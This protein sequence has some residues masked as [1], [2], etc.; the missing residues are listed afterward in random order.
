MSNTVAQA[1]R[2]VVEAALQGTCY[3]LVDVEFKKER[4]GWNLIIYADK[5]QG[6]TLDDCEIINN[7][8]DPLLDADPEVA[9]KHDH[10]V[11]SSPGLDRPMKTTRDFERRM[12][13]KIEIKL[14]EP[15]LKKRELVAVLDA[16]DE[17]NIH[18]TVEQKG[19]TQ[20]LTVARS[21]IALARLHIEF[22]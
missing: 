10:L 22:E 2:A 3:E 14:F 5:P 16:V 15:A 13:E 1:A 17:E 21:N 20:A 12:G 18:L 6:L 8:I 11:V 19:K 4:N 9:D 7:L